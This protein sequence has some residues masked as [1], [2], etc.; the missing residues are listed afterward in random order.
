MARR[1]AEPGQ[2]DVA[3]AYEAAVPLSRRRVLLD[4][5]AAELGKR[6]PFSD[7]YQPLRDGRL[8]LIAHQ[9]PPPHLNEPPVL[10]PVDL[11]DKVVAGWEQNPEAE[12]T[13]ASLTGP[14]RNLSAGKPPSWC[15]QARVKA[16]REARDRRELQRVRDLPRTIYWNAGKISFDGMAFIDCRVIRAEDLESHTRGSIPHGH[17][18]RVVS[19]ACEQLWA[20]GARDWLD[21]KFILPIIAEEL[22]S[23]AGSNSLLAS[24]PRAS[25]EKAIGK[26]R[27]EAREKAGRKP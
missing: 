25:F 23:R 7:Y 21:K 13:I 3:A 26:A 14:R 20:D 12:W 10:L 15:D 9:A 1:K 6:K 16:E 22:I 11:V 17:Q 4:A 19:K 18:Q 24:V 5:I 8:R 27:A 2:I